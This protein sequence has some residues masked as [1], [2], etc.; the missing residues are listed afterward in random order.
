MAVLLQL[1]RVGVVGVGTRG[2]T[3]AAMIA[4]ILATGDRLPYITD[5]GLILDPNAPVGDHWPDHP[6]HTLANAR[7]AE[8]R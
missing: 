8:N 3:Y 4:T 7:D 1:C 6:G 2:G 5:I